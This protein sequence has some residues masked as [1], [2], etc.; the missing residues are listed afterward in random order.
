MSNSDDSD[1]NPFPDDEEEEEEEKK[2]LADVSTGDIKNTNIVCQ[3]CKH[4]LL[5]T[6]NE[7]RLDCGHIIC[8]NC[9]KLCQ[10]HQREFCPICFK[11]VLNF[12]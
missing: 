8:T 7:V 11:K 3:F 2:E 5:E 1:W 12:K 4:A 6:E 9:F 10:S